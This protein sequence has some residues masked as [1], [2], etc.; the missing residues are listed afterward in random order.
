MN[1]LWYD[2]ETFG[3]NP[4]K[5]RPAQFAAIRTDERL[6][7][8]GD[9]IVLYCRPA[10]DFLPSIDACLIT[11]ITPQEALEKGVIERKFFAAI[12][13]EMLKEGTCSVGYNSI[14]FDSEVTRH[15][16]YRNFTEAYDHEWRNNT[17]RWDLLD[18]IRT[19]YAFRPG[20][21]VWPKNEDGSPSFRLSELTRVNAIDHEGAHDALVDVRA[22]IALAKLV[23][24]REPNLFNYLLK[25]RNKYEVAGL[26]QVGQPFLHVSKTVSASKGCLAVEVPL[27][28]SNTNKNSI[29]TFNLDYDPEILIKA[30]AD[31]LRR[32]VFSKKDDLQDGENRVGL[33]ALQINKCPSVMPRSYLTDK[34]AARLGVNTALHD[35]H[36]SVL[37][38]H[39]KSLD[40]QKK[41]RSVFDDTTFEA[42]KNVDWMLYSGGFPSDYDKKQ[43]SKLLAV[44]PNQLRDFDGKFTEQRF[45]TMLF[46]FRARNYLKTLNRGELDAWDSYR[47]Q[48]IKDS[49]DPECG[50][51][52]KIQ[53][54]MAA[55]AISAR[56]Q[57]ILSAL[58]EWHNFVAEPSL[59]NNTI[60]AL[61][62]MG[63]HHEMA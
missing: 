8:I 60:N 19:A 27:V 49:Q 26:A 18:V 10:N 13:D 5:D 22:T 45:D 31:E 23:K 58:I 50:Y 12:R 36:M 47:A 14:S 56:D 52:Q 24:E 59:S 29:V 37:S 57:G 7:Q 17:S 35:Q 21:L 41:I 54:L 44:P 2:Y 33:S 38:G 43:F 1:F 25:I 39:I 40:F 4:Q 15:G 34:N 9:P 55:P 3:A 63:D 28:K 20:C 42:P 32:L 48:S 16:L 51:L 62:D 46:R 11:G 30:S 6:N 53:E 61:D